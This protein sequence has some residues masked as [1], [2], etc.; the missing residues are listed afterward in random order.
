M[1]NARDKAVEVLR[2]FDVQIP[3][4]STQEGSVGVADVL[5]GVAEGE[6]DTSIFGLAC[7]LRRSDVP[8]EVAIRLVLE[9]AASCSPPFPEPEAMKCLYSAYGRYHPETQPLPAGRCL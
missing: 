1:P 6:R 8:E 4:E 9:A 7:K 3:S 2:A 5:A